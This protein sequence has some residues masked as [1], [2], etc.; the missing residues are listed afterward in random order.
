MIHQMQSNEQFQNFLAENPNVLIEFFA[1]WCVHCQHEQPILEQASA[2]LNEQ[3]VQVIQCDVD[4]LEELAGQFGVE[5]TPTF[6]FAKNG[7]PV[8]KNEG[9]L[10]YEEIFEFVK[11][12]EEA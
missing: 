5:A 3:G 9:E 8:L 12:G 11:Q 1:T 10:P 7:Q 4:K 2:Q 6:F